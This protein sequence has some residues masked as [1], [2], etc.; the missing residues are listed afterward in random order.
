MTSSGGVNTVSGG[1]WWPSTVRSNR[2][3]ACWATSSAGG[4]SVV[5]CWSAPDLIPRSCSCDQPDTE[6]LLSE[7]PDPDGRAVYFRL[8]DLNQGV[9]DELLGPSAPRHEF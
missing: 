6:L 7:F 8:R 1:S 2:C 9:K 4:A 3:T 5:R